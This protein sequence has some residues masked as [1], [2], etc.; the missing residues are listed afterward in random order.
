M[1]IKT[2][3]CTVCTF[4]VDVTLNLKNI[5]ETIIILI[6]VCALKLLLSIIILIQ[7]FDHFYF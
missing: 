4:G 7:K 1:S 6:G 5:G 3:S 2:F